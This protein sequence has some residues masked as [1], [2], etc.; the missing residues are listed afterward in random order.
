MAV[1]RMMTG[2]IPMHIGLMGHID[3]GKTELARVLSEKVSTAGLDKHP[4]SKRRGITID[5]GFTMFNLDKYLVTLVDAPGHADLIRSVVAGANIIDG[6][7]LVVAADEG[8]MIQ[9]GEHLIVLQSMGVE[10]VVVALSKCDLVNETQLSTLE[11]EI[12]TIMCSAGYSDSKIIQVSALTGSGID[13]LRNA[14]RDVII[15]R[16]RDTKGSFLMP[17]D[18]AFSVKGHGTVVTGTVLRGSVALDE[19][20]D[21]IPL[22]KN[23]RV[24]SIQVFGENRKSAIAGD[25]IGINIPSIDEKDLRRGDY[26]SSPDT[27]E[28]GISAH[29]EIRL[30]PLYVGRITN[31]MVLSAT[32]GM[33]TVTAEIIPYVIEDEREV[34]IDQTK[35][36]IVNA[37][38][39]FQRNIGIEEGMPVLLMRTD[40]PPNTMRIIGSGIITRLVPKIQLFR[41][42]IRK[43][44]ISRIR[45]EDVLVESLT[46]SKERAEK[47][48]GI[49]LK[50]ASGTI[51]TIKSAFGTRGVVSVI[52]DGKVSE[53]EE[54]SYETLIEEEF[55][56]GH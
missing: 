46:Q 9:T 12:S 54:V 49:T 2:L 16:K 21:I 47:L 45:D 50:T 39:L 24:R 5:L 6:A 13:N 48:S 53:A 27:L 15:P 34:I 26:L 25:R 20:I 23:A 43:G 31:R 1:R 28:N 7:I 51:G 17:I 32:I 35:D 3:H 55:E 11:E 40:L 37:A 52:F 42:R 29:C 41:K 56:F 18:H 19:T 30:N 4:Q 8:P 38:I 14:L 44:K 33:P 36:S 10:T 22:R